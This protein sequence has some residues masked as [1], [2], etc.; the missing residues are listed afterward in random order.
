MPTLSDLNTS[1]QGAVAAVVTPG[2]G[3]SGSSSGG[4]SSGSLTTLTLMTW[5]YTQ[6]FRIISA[7]RDSNEAITS[8]SIMWPD[9]TFGVFTTDT[10][11]TSFPGAIDAWHATHVG[12]TTQT[13]T[14][15]TVTRDANGAVISQPA[16][17]VT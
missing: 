17:T 2:S 11:S 6:A 9:G 7:T 16:I 15:P 3:S 13:V 4:S 5:G 10:A 14:Q 12:V 1:L 8:A